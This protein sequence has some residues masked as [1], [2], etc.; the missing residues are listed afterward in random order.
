MTATALHLYEA[1]D[2]IEIV[3]D[4][5]L[6]HDEELR[7]NEGALPDEL[8][9]LLA[10]VEG[11]FATKAERVAL[12]IRELVTTGKAIKLEEERLY[13]RRKAM[14]NAADRLKRY[15]EMNMLVAEKMRIDGKLVTLR[16]QKNPPH[17]ERDRELS[18]EELTT[19]HSIDAAL[20]LFTP[21]RYDLN[22]AAVIAVSR[23]ADEKGK[24]IG[25]ECPI[26]GL[27]VVQG[28][29]LRIA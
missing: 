24:V 4:W 17:L 5:I 28:A 6:E 8:A 27:R 22:G 20:V 29:S 25:Y 15:L 2:A 19:L 14:E 12:F 3:R 7:A 18:Q 23:K 16:I 9:E 21:A 10:K 26:E 11:D 1:T 13:A